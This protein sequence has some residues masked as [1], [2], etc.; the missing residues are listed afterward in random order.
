MYALAQFPSQGDLI[1][2]IYDAFGI[3][4]SKSEQILDLK[5]ENRSLQKSLQR[6]AKEEG[7]NF[8]ENFDLHMQALHSA[9][10]DLF[11]TWH[12]QHSILDTLKDLFKCYLEVV[13]ENHTYLNKQDSFEFIIKTTILPRLP[14]SILKYK[15]SY[16]DFF[17]DVHTPQDFYWFLESN[18][19]TPL[20]NI[21]QWIY[22]SE[23]SNQNSFHSLEQSHLTSYESDQQEKDLCNVDNWLKDKTLPAFATLK[24]TFDRAFK[25]L[26]I[27]KERQ[28][29]YL[30]FLLIA[31]F[32]TYC[33]QQIKEHYGTI[34]LQTMSEKL[35]S[36]LGAIYKDFHLFY[37][38]KMKAI[39]NEQKNIIASDP[40]NIENNVD[41]E[42]MMNFAI[43]KSF[44][45]NCLQVR[46]RVSFACTTCRAYK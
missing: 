30:F 24:A 20:N 14:I 19:Q 8:L 46:Y 25:S 4:P 21:M 44:S 13:L 31:R 32:C 39:I 35:R 45:K 37:N 26:A 9:I 7:S 33:S 36:Y 6:F 11:P 27:P 15:E 1:K 10:A 16:A 17:K 41:V 34:F 18:N 23:N 3:I 28:E 22:R 5:I 43:F 29:S 42:E 12:L 38:D 40:Y 2:F